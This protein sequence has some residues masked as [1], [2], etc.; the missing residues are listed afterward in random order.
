MAANISNAKTIRDF[1]SSIKV[2]EVENYKNLTVFPLYSDSAHNNGYKLLDEAIGTERFIVTEVSESGS[3]P[4]LKVTNSLDADV[5]ILDG[6]LLIGAKQNRVVNTTIVVG[7][8]KEVVIPVSCVEQGRWHYRERRFSSGKANLYASLRGEKSRSVYERLR[9]DSSYASDQHEIWRDISE[10]SARFS[11]RSE[12]GAMND[13]YEHY[14]KDLKLYE[15]EF[16]PHPEQIGFITVIGNKIAG[17]DI[18]G[19]KSLLPK[20]YGRLLKGYI[21]D[22]LDRAYKYK[23]KREV[24]QKGPVHEGERPSLHDEVMK[25]LS[26]MKSAR[27]E[28]Y[29]SVGEGEDLRFERK[30]LNGFALVNNNAVVHIAAF[31]GFESKIIKT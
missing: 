17:T 24:Q 15:N 23:G 31:G 6:D 9:T 20:V 4:E 22:A 28:T 10:K 5:I 19:I 13:I 16:K 18:F 27:K 30:S 21:L 14:D 3:V 12:T 26:D 2:G 1:I 11:V 7:R 25:F 8:N 29:K